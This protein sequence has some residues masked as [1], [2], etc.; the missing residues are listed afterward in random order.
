[1]ALYCSH[2]FGDKLFV[3]CLVLIAQAICIHR[4]A[5]PTPNQTSQAFLAHKALPIPNQTPQSISCP[6]QKLQGVFICPSN[7]TVIMPIQYEYY[8]LNEIR[9]ELYVANNMLCF[10]VN[11]S[12]YCKR[13]TK[14]SIDSAPTLLE[15]KPSGWGFRRGLNLRSAL[16]FGLFLRRIRKARTKKNTFHVQIL[17]SERLLI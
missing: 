8:S 9:T 13:L 12:L 2:S 1:M 17:V 16:F 7:R 10:M 15:N 11:K 14:L 5:L 3:S 6:R 4:N